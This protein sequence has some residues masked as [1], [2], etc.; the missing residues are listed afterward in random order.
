MRFFPAT[1]SV[2]QNNAM[3]QYC[4][5]LIKQQG[6]G[7]WAVDEKAT[8]TFIGLTGLH[9]PTDEPPFSPCIEVAW[10]IRGWC[11]LLIGCKG[12]SA[13]LPR[14]EQR[15]RQPARSRL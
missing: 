15:R 1:L 5:E 14:A 6:W 13:H 12:S 8:A 4:R 7:V 11:S 10:P 2:E 3:A 9:R